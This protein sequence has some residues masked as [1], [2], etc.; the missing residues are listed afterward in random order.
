MLDAFGGGFTAGE[1]K[2]LSE[3]RAI[4]P[5]AYGLL[6][7]NGLAANSPVWLGL[8]VMISLDAGGVRPP[9]LTT[10]LRPIGNRLSREGRPTA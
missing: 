1:A 8:G 4:F 3:L 5:N 2:S 6:P 7:R 9:T 10:E